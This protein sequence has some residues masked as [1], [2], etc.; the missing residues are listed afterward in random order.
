MQITRKE[1]DHILT[2]MEANDILFIDAEK[3]IKIDKERLCYK[4]NKI[5]RFHIVNILCAEYEITK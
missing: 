2:T 1:I 5:E 4:L 3:P